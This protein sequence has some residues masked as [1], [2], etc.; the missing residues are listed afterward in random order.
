MTPPVQTLAPRD[1]EAYLTALTSL[2][3]DLLQVRDVRPIPAGPFP[4]EAHAL[5]EA[6]D[7]LR[8]QFDEI[9]AFIAPLARGELSAPA[10]STDNRLARPLV[11][12]H[13]RLRRLARQTQEIARGDYSR[14]L[15]FMGELSTAFNAMAVLLE[16]REQSLRSEIA[17]RHQAEVDLQHERDLLVAGPVVTLRWDVDEAG[18][19]LYVSPNITEFG[20]TVEELTSGRRTYDSMIHPADLGWVV[21]DGNDKSR[22]G[23][24][25]WTQEYRLVDASGDTRWIRDFTHAVRGPDG[26]ITSYEG[27]IIDVTAQK[28]TE[29]VLR[30]REEQMRMLSLS[31]DLTGL[32]N[33]RGLFALGEHLLRGARRRELGLSVMYLDVDDLKEINDRFGHRHGDDALRAVAEI[34]RASVRDSDVA[35]RAGGD[36]FVVVAEDEPRITRALRQR[37]ERR[38]TA[39]NAEGGH[40]FRLSFSIG[41]T[42]WDTRE[43]VTLQD[44]TDRA[45]RN[46]HEVRR[47]NR[48]D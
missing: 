45:E 40:P 47:I 18:T 14:R 19:V 39:F 11:E 16:E 26:E 12:M 41:V 4:P 20:Y 35:A 9:I 10:P 31:D 2:I 13:Q 22:S 5:A 42:D 32:Y 46:L 25:G 24:D 30:K 17:R 29:S 7:R 8:E 23:L 37:L 6:V 33:R 21:E 36:E 43:T 44:L 48:T 34:V 15:D 28:R 3:D 38:A 27:Y 1:L